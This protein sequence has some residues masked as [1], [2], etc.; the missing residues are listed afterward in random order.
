[1]HPY[2]NKPVGMICVKDNAKWFSVLLYETLFWYWDACGRSKLWKRQIVNAGSS[3][4]QY[5]SAPL[6][7]IS[8]NSLMLPVVKLQ[9]INSVLIGVGCDICHPVPVSCEGNF[10][11]NC[12]Q[13]MVLC[14]KWNF[15]SLDEQAVE[16]RL[17]TQPEIL[18]VALDGH[19][20]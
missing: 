16:Y 18:F 1:M 3:V 14:W 4:S 17:K 19:R 5:L 2:F 9:F 12:H 7:A 10:Q 11:G 6:P 8:K 15:L 13:N 20:T